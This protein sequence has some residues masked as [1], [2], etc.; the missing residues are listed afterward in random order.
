M[1]QVWVLMQKSGSTNT[2][3]Y[4]KTL[5]T[6]KEYR[7]SSCPINPIKSYIFEIVL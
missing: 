7:V 1:Q 2:A 4:G 3:Q 5:P 6:E